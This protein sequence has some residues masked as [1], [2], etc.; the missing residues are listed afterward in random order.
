MPLVAQGNR[1]HALAEYRASLT[2]AEAL[3]RCDPANVQWQRDLIVSSMLPFICFTAPRTSFA[4]A[5]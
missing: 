4:R 1:E 5:R 2:I 3:A